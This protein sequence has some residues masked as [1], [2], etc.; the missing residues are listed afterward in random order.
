MKST[1]AL[2]MADVGIAM[3]V[4]GTEV[5]LETADIALMNDD[6]SKSPYERIKRLPIILPLAKIAFI[7]YLKHDKL[8]SN[9]KKYD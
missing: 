8:V 5:A 1:P 4:K 7:V 6:I 2:S 9:N 3:G